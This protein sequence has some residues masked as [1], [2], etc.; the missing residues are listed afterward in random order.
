MSRGALSVTQV[1]CLW[2]SSLLEFEELVP[3]AALLKT[4]LCLAR[5]RHCEETWATRRA[6]DLSWL[7]FL[8]TSGGMG[9]ERVGHFSYTSLVV[10][11]EA[12]QVC[13][14]FL[15]C[16]A[17]ICKDDVATRATGAQVDWPQNS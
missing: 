14:R 8:P 9:E 11:V 6:E 17:V 7:L 12:Q 10:G 15:L 13:Q 4:R 1:T 5:F 3:R 16:T 2:M